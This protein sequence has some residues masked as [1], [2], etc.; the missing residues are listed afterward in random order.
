MGFFRARLNLVQQPDSGALMGLCHACFR[1]FRQQAA[2]AG[3]QISHPAWTG[4]AK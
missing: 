4:Y 3:P 2:G 1:W